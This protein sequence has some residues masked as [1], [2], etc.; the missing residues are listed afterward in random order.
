MFFVRIHWSLV[1]ELKANH[2][3]MILENSNCFY[4]STADKEKKK[5]VCIDVSDVALI[6][7][8]DYL[9]LTNL[10]SDTSKIKK[11]KLD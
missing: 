8:N 7:T 3:N 5:I 10:K 6:E 4:F 9:L 1:A 2:P 11:L